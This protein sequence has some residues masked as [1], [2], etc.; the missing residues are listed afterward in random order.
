MKGDAMEELAKWMI[1]AVLVAG[2][3]ISLGYGLGMMWRAWQV[4]AA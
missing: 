3:A 1:G 2:G 4:V